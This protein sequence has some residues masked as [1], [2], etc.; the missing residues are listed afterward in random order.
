MKTYEIR[1]TQ[2]VTGYYE[3]YLKVEAKNKAEAN[4][5]ID[6]MTKQEIDDVV[7]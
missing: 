6:T 5:I 7:D 4:K 2:N 3:G 1:V